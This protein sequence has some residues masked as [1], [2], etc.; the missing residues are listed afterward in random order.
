MKLEFIRYGLDKRRVLV[1]YLQ[2]FG[3]FGL[4]TGWYLSP[5]LASMASFGLCLLM[6]LGFGL[7]IKIRDGFWA[8]LPSLLY[9]ILSGGLFIMFL[10][11]SLES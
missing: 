9:A 7:R 6:I 11:L 1:G 4:L 8:S 5:F 3:G 10:R 2:I